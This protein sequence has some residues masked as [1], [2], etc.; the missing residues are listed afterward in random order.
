MFPIALVIHR[1]NTRKIRLHKLLYYLYTHLT[2]QNFLFTPLLPQFPH[3]FIFRYVRF[4]S[5][6]SKHESTLPIYT[7]PKTKGLLIHHFI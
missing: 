6:P 3:Y 4:S 1:N 7:K 2:F 5:C